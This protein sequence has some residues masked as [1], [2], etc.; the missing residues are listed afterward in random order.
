[1]AQ[2]TNWAG[3]I[4]YRAE[5]IERPDS[6]D[7]LRRLVASSRRVR[8]L[9]SRHSFTTMAD[10]DGVLVS[11][12]GLPDGIE[13]DSENRRVAVCGGVTYGAL[14]QVLHERGWA[15]A[16]LAS[17]PHIT[18]AGA[19]ATGT[20]GS[21]DDNQSLAA[22]VAGLT[23]MGP[24]GETRTLRRQ[25]P[26][27]DGSVVGLG[28]LGIVTEL[29]LDIEPTFDVWQAVYRGLPWS[30]LLDDYD[31]ITRDHYSVSV[32]TTLG[33]DVQVWVKQRGG[34]PM[35]TLCGARRVVGA[36]HMLPDMDASAVTDQTG[37]PGPWLGRLPHFR[38]EFTPSNGDELQSEFLLPRGS[39]R[40][41]LVRLRAVAGGFRDIL[42]VLEIRSV[43]ADGLWL[44]PAHSADVAGLHFTWRS[45][46]SAV[47][48]A[49]HTI[50]DAVLPLGARPHWGKVFVCG[51]D[52][53]VSA[54]PQLPQFADLRDEVDPRRVFGNDWL[55]AILP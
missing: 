54:Y 9:G 7:E 41:A 44:S 34:T 32:F 10:T 36:T 13:I 46:A 12:A 45:D 21:G 1:M 8:A 2:Q 23:I 4:T 33:E 5:R 50:E 3:N 52:A 22:A 15:L 43:A 19:V 40:E 38:M 30:A 37:E 53:L 24:D 26:E 51:T 27:F 55:D 25:D 29:V 16:N 35:D 6:I 14:A 31:V 48:A 17:L 47:A 20:H 18:V 49:L 42:Q 39:L 28:A 11:L